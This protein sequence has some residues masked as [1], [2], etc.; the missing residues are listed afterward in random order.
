MPRT[1]LGLIG[2]FLQLLAL[3]LR[4][5]THLAAEHLFL[6][7]QLAFYGERRRKPRRLDTPR[8]SRWW[9][10]PDSSSGGASSRLCNRRRSCDGTVRPFAES[11]GGS[12]GAVAVRGF[13]RACRS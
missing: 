5:H 6:R 2:G 13:P 9:S 10:S 1:V 8:D 3:G 11:G 4:S 12:H 7:K